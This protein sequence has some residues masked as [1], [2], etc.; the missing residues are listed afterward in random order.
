MYVLSSK[1]YQ[2]KAEK[3]RKR[4]KLEREREK[5][6]KGEE[7]M[8]DIVKERRG[9]NRMPTYILRFTQTYR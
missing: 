6:A 5:A 3:D 7:G 1:A 8:A 9:E 2:I 4:L